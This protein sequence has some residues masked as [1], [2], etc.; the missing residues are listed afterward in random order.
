VVVCTHSERRL[1][2]LRECV[3][4]LRA[5]DP[6]P[7]EVIVVVDS[8]RPLLAR[9]PSI[10]PF[11][12]EM[13]PSPG[14]GVSAAR[15]A[16]IAAATGELIAFI[17]DDATAE[18][19]W[20]REI[21]RPF[22]DPD[23]VAVGGRIVPRWEAGAQILPP[24]LYWVVGCTYRG[25]PT[26]AR[27]ITRPIACNMAARREALLDSGGFPLDFGPSGPT[28]KSHSNEE[29]ALAVQM[30][31]RHGRDSIWYTPAA[32][33]RHYVPAARTTWKY[34]WQR[35]VAEGIS[36]ADVRMRYGAAAMGYDRSYAVRTLV[37]AIVDY[38]AT[39]VWK[40]DR[41]SGAHALASAGGLLVTAAA[42]GGRL[43]AAGGR[44]AVAPH[45][46]SGRAT[47]RA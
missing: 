40:R 2:L 9:L 23:I 46:T 1:A 7:H 42:F 4:S 10:L 43:A 33:V 3:A 14:R 28:P 31:R 29:I 16:G 22:D 26:T 35:C 15:N 45:A 17:D 39:G 8:N 32:V 41:L 24:E 6:P 47:R 21:S 18:P 37:P 44:R 19:D 30:R 25:H 20:V 11:G 13:I 34:L 5:G 27:P 38:A 36:K 12:V